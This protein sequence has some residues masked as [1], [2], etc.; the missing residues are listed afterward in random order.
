MKL[1]TAELEESSEFLARSETRYR[2]LVENANSIIVRW[3]LEGRIT[4]VNKFA[5]E[6]FGY[7]ENEI[8]GRYAVGTI[9]PE[10][11]S[12]GRDLS[13]LTEDILSNPARYVSNVNENI[14][15]N[16]ERVWVA[17][18][19]KPVV[20]D[21]GRIVEVLSIGN[22][23][24]ARRRLEQDLIEEKNL[25]DLMVDSL[26]GIFYLFDSYGNFLRWNKNFETVSG[27][28][29]QEI[30]AMR[31]SDFFA[32]DEKPILEEAIKDVFSLGQQTVEADF[33]AKDGTSNCHLFSGMRIVF[34]GVPCLLGM[35]LDITERRRAEIA[36]KETS[37]MLRSIFEASPDAIMVMNPD[38]IIEMWNRS[39]ERLF[40]WSEQEVLG[41]LNPL[42]KEG[43]AREEFSRLRERVLQ[44]ENVTG[45]ELK[46][47][48]KD[49]TTIDV[50][51]S[52]APLRDAKR[53]GCRNSGDF[54]G[55]FQAKEVGGGPKT[56]S[57]SHR[58][59]N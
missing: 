28:S 9:V 34:D 16:G 1:R 24:T 54:V 47:I 48:R 31:P 22:D 52:N 45:L 15:K 21:D 43:A 40:G 56:F 37:E 13:G 7:D 27:R 26:P 42:V 18:T 8:I 12:T 30:S 51:L 53:Q 32:D 5:Q 25:N 4:F 41:L 55:H 36:L 3:N 2:E 46:R 29:G 20:D 44:G 14:K 50:S 17:W 6:F 49:G 10:E 39:A 19:N 57:H 23:I 11:E 59:V 35:G 58:A 38:G 33:L